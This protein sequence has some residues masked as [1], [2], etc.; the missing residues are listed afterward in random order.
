MTVQVIFNASLA[1]LLTAEN[2]VRFYNVPA[3]AAFNIPASVIDPVPVPAGKSPTYAMALVVTAEEV[4]TT[5]P[6][7]VT[8]VVSPTAAAVVPVPIAMCV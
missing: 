4:K 3:E 1:V 8:R 6:A 5:L 2:V 7:S